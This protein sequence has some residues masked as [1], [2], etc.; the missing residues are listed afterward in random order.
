MKKHLKVVLGVAAAGAVA[1][2][3]F[4]ASAQAD[5]NNFVACNTSGNYAYVAFP[6]RNAASY[7][8]NPG[9]CWQAS[10]SGLSNDEAVAYED[11]NGSFQA[12]KYIYFNDSSHV[13]WNF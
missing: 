8:L 5:T 2:L 1:A 6:Y 12:V 10:L 13:L 11:I 9:E 7:V 4:P 3:A